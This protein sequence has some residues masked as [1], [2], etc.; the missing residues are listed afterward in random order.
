MTISL[1]DVE[2]AARQLG[3]A[4]LRTPC[5]A[6]PELSE[7]CGTPVVLKLENLQLSGSFKARGALVRLIALDEAQRRAGVV[8]VSAGNHAQGVAYHAKRLEVPAVIVM[9][10]GT[11]FTKVERT[12]RLGARVVLDGETLGD[13][14]RVAYALAEREGL[15]FVHPYDDAAVIAGQGTVAIE[16]LVDC[17]DLDCLVVPIGGGGLIAGMAVAAKA[18]RPGI[19]IVGVQAELYPSMVGALQGN[20]LRSGGQTVAEG[21]AVKTPGRLTAPIVRELVD[22]ILLVGETS[23][24]RAIQTLTEVGKIVAEGAGA[25][26]MAAVLAHRRHFEGKRVG[27]VVSGGNIDARLLASILMRSLCYAGRLARL[28]IE[29]SDVPGM[30]AKAAG[31]IA[32][33]G[34]N[35][36]EIY[37]QRL[38][39]D[40]PVKFADVDVVIETTSIA[41]V[42][43]IVERL[44]MAGLPTRVLSSSAEG[45]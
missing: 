38:F 5:L 32:S 22:D 35:I 16:M 18:L 19:E 2:Q 28:R 15:V 13:A 11:P 44:R 29:V 17:P 30:L 1:A 6:S 41:H 9:P 21:I 8:A 34:G 25:A 14:E 31:I 33:D 26:A 37:H 7:M 10:K 24:E 4:V 20:S 43:E 39:A 3:T 27:V 12:H 36:I 45:D 42:N 40:V 23:L